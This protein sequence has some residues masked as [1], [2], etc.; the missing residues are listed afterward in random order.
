MKEFVQAQI[1]ALSSFVDSDHFS[2]GQSNR[3]LH[4]HDISHHSG[5]LLAG[6]IWPVTTGE[7]A[8]ILSWT[9]FPRNLC[10]DKTR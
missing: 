2:V 1:N 9:Y 7:V 3:E 4:L 5:I 6:I 10:T 8:E